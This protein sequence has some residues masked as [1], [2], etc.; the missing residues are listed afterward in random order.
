MI[1][2]TLS[3]MHADSAEFNDSIKTYVRKRLT[4]AL[5]LLP[6]GKFPTIDNRVQAMADQANQGCGQSYDLF[7]QRFSGIFDYEFPPGCL[8]REQAL[9][10][11]KGI[12][13]P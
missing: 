2:T 4:D 5:G 11:A 7:V 13:H 9:V 6:G 10:S 1:V 8:D 3:E 12:C